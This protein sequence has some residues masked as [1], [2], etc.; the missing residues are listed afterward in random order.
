MKEKDKEGSTKAKWK[1]EKRRK[2]EKRGRGYAR[3]ALA[4]LLDVGTPGRASRVERPSAT[5]VRIFS[6]PQV[7]R[8]DLAIG[9]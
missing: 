4:R 8:E 7:R 6:P 3:N 1:R 9:T 2:E 5:V